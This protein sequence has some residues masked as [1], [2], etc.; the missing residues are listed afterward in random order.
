MGVG[1]ILFLKLIIQNGK[2]ICKHQI[3][4]SQQLKNNQ[5]YKQINYML[6]VNSSSRVVVE[7]SSSRVED[8]YTNQC[9]T[10]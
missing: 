2:I 6:K 3:L 1:A 9:I 4:Y 5:N 8:K 7:N 10:N